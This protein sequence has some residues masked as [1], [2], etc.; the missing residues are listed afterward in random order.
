VS[1][2]RLS[3][4]LHRAAV[5]AFAV[6][7]VGG[8]EAPKL[9]IA[10]FPTTGAP[11]A[12]PH[13]LDGL[14]WLY[15]YGYEEATAA[16]RQAQ[17]VDPRFAMA[18]WGEALSYNRPTWFIQ[19]LPAARRALARLGPTPD[20]RRRR[21][22]TERERAYL[23]AIELLYA[24]GDKVARDQAYARAMASIVAKY[25][26][27]LEAKCL[28]AFALL[29]LAPLDHAGTRAIEAGEVAE[30]IFRRNPNHPGAAHVIIHAFD[31][32]EDVARALPA[33]RAYAQIAPSSSHAHHM[34]AHVFL[35]LG[36]WHDAARSDEASYEASTRRVETL[37]LGI[38][39]RDY[40]SLSWLQYEWLQQGRLGKAREAMQPFEE[41]LART[42]DPKFRDD[43][44]S[45]RAYYV[46]E[47]GRW[48]ELAGQSRFDNADEL[49]ALGLAA[50][51]LGDVGR[52]AAVVEQ[53]G[54]VAATDR[55]EIRR[56]LAEIM[57]R[58]VDALVQLAAGDRAAAVAAAENAVALEDSLPLP[59]GRPRPIKASHELLAEILIEVGRP[60]D[61]V[62]VLER[63]LRRAANRSSLVMT[64]A[65]AQHAA[66]DRAAAARTAR[67]ALDNWRLADSAFPH[68]EPA[69]A[70]LLAGASTVAHRA[71]GWRSGPVVRVF[72][73]V[74]LA[75]GLA[76]ALILVRRRRAAKEGRAS[77]SRRE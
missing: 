24:D 2:T 20:A 12:Q 42:G 21:A 5:A 37:G 38:Q 7:V 69:R 36:E 71:T 64:L 55:E 75:V 44:A 3:S 14:K 19:D 33:A 43:L 31:N 65:R 62:P 13:F 49:F 25:P 16:F 8:A 48:N 30:E 35:Q 9:G 10:E 76:G 22:G 47:S 15:S 74:G 29:G 70:I 67:R 40:H 59:V 34:P 50:A 11:A 39:Q 17:A 4:W 41:A 6:A 54:K 27:D 23:D 28:Y 57:R 66:G 18:Y 63:G 32:R 77:R 58:E 56:V 72:A 51:R 52:A 60:A 46:I 26:D 68:L 45:L 1:P 53:L 73:I 61:A